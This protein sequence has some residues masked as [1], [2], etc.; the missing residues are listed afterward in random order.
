MNKAEYPK[1]EIDLPVE[2]D[3]RVLI[4]GKILPIIDIKIGREL[5]K[6]TVVTVAFYAN[7]TGLKEPA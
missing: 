7:V 6:L 1:V 4:D 5:D 2:G 3:A